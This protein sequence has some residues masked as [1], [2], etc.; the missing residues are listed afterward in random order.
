M[1]GVELLPLGKKNASSNTHVSF[2]GLNDHLQEWSSRISEGCV[3]VCR[4]V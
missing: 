1:E 2:R 3:L 4:H